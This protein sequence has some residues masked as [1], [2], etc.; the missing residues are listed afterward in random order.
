MRAARGLALV[1]ALAAGPAAANLCDGPCAIALDFAD[2]G[3][4][5]SD[6]AT[7]T[8]GTGG[9]RVLGTG[10][11]L[12]LGTGGSLAPNLDPPDMSGG[13]SLVLGTGGSIQF[14]TGGMLD[15][16]A[17]GNI[18]LD[19]GTA[20]A[21][22][23]ASGVAVDSTTSVHLG[24]LTAAGTASLTAGGSITGGDTSSPIHFDSAADITV[25]SDA[26]PIIELNAP[27][28]G[29]GGGFSDCSAGCPSGGTSTLGSPTIPSESNL[30]GP[31]T[32]GAGGPGP[33]TL[34]P[35][36]LAGLLGRRRRR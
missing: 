25:A 16:A 23:G 2:G 35:L 12:T 10:G 5:A 7:I 27:A 20:L 6:G 30:L 15:T 18:T 32:P 29:D 3:T 8:F 9:A 26:D 22:T 1:V 11:S 24:D 33:L 14:G 28:S 17:A 13:G 34:L 31:Q 21:V 36:A 4:L 19:E